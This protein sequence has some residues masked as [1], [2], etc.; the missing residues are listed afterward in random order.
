MNPAQQESTQSAYDKSLFWL[1]RVYHFDIYEFSKTVPP[2]QARLFAA[3]A[4]LLPPIGIFAGWAYSLPSLDQFTF[5]FTVFSA[6]PALAVEGEKSLLMLL[7]AIMLFSYVLLAI[8]APIDLWVRSRHEQKPIAWEDC[9]VFALAAVFI[10]LLGKLFIETPVATWLIALFSFLFSALDNINPI[11][12]VPFV[13]L[14]LLVYIFDDI[15]F[16]IGHRLAHNVR[17]IWKL[18][19][20]QHHRATNMTSASVSGDFS[21]FFLNGGGGSFVT[22]IVGKSLFFKMLSDTDASS[23]LGA[24]FL[25]TFLKIIN[26]TVSHSYSAYLLFSKYKM[27]AM[28]ES[29]FVTGR[30]HY[31]HHSKLAEHNVASGCNFAAQ[32]TWLDKIM[33]TYA[34]PTEKIPPTGLFHEKMAPGNP[35]KFALDQWIKFGRELY[36]NSPRYWLKIFFADPSYEPPNP[37]R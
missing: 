27:L 4:L 24:A 6:S 7:A 10:L 23:A 35:L 9:F 8:L 32:F 31:V 37:V 19:H 29:F 34:K 14:V 3:L 25:I 2:K 28:L 16:Y 13:V 22:A 33:G 12:S 21:A 36:Q 11:T 17:V 26:H 20:M 18:G 1:N 30:I 5:S 15:F